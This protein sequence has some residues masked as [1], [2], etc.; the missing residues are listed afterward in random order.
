MAN[1]PQEKLKCYPGYGNNFKK[2]RESKGLT[3]EQLYEKI[4]ISDKTIS[5]IETEQRIPTTGQINIYSDY[6][7]ASLDFL[8]GRTHIAN[9]DNNLLSKYTGL[10]DETITMLV[11]LNNENNYLHRYIIDNIFADPYFY[12]II[13]AL[14]EILTTPNQILD[15]SYP[16][17]P[18]TKRLL[19]ETL[20]K[21]R[22]SMIINSIINS[23]DQLGHTSNYKEAL[24]NGR[25]QR[26]QE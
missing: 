17:L 3:Q 7:D 22:F 6:F 1:K 24:N 4:H 18:I 16:N 8:T 9:P 13:N 20:I 5:Q 15:N 23:Y 14:E 25:Y 21:E 10:S 19:L 2:L 11:S 26:E 12:V